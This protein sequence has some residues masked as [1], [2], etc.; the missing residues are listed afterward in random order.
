MRLQMYRPSVGFFGDQGSTK[1]ITV[2][3][4]AIA[5]HAAGTGTAKE[6]CRL[7]HSTLVRP[8]MNI[9]RCLLPALVCAFFARPAAA[10]Y[11]IAWSAYK[12]LGQSSVEEPNRILNAPGG[13]YYVDAGVG[14]GHVVFKLDSTGAKLWSR[15]VPG[16]VGDMAAG[17]SGVALAGIAS[18]APGYRLCVAKFDGSGNQLWMKTLPGGLN[19]QQARTALDPAGN[20]IVSAYLFGASGQGDYDGRLVKL[21]GLTGATVFDVQTATADVREQFVKV[22]TD[23]SGSIYVL[24][25]GTSGNWL[26]RQ[27]TPAGALAWEDKGAGFD[28]D[29]QVDGAG[30]SYLVV[31]SATI[32][33]GIDVT[34]FNNL[35]QYVWGTSV[36][37]LRNYPTTTLTPAGNLVV[38]ARTGTGLSFVR[39]GPTSD[40]GPVTSLAGFAPANTGK[41]WVSVDGANNV[42]I[43]SFGTE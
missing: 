9:S 19:I 3:P 26:L 40:Q 21:D 30:N 7:Y 41:G 10:Q 11:P 34:K 35:G 37:G 22:A 2:L 6:G 12:D 23:S 8:S 5:V 42:Y 29:F 39:L 15:A 14:G 24:G 17:N 31:G 4:S 28:P 32:A 20:V 27:Y 18:S 1:T 43:A 33:T 13:G 36:D 25:K 38:V 16:S